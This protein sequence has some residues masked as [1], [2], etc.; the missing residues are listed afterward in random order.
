MPHNPLSWIDD[1][2][3][4]L[5]QKHLRRRL[6]TRDGPQSARLSIDG[7]ELINFGSN[8]YLGLGR[9]SALGPRR[10][11]GRRRA[12]AGAAGPVRW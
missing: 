10:G 11:R 1:E 8:D 12:K 6:L 3:A 2:L 5:E 7:R 4:A 9:R